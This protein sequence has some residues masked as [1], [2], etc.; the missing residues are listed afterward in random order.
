MS[1]PTPPRYVVL[2]ADVIEQA[3]VPDKPR[4]ALL[5]SFIRLLS[6][7][8]EAKYQNTP[9]LPE[10]ELIAFLKLSRRQYFDQKANMELLGW[11]RSSHP[12]PGFVQFS[13][14]RPVNEK[15]TSSAS[16][17]NRTNG[18]E[19]P[20]VVGEESL[21]RNSDPDT[22]PHQ[23]TVPA[24]A[25]NCTAS[26]ENPL[27]GGGE[28]LDQNLTSDMHSPPP[29]TPASAENRTFPATT[30]ILRHTDLL[31]NG[32][33]VA[34]RDL[35][36]RDPLHAL[37]WCAYAYANRRKV[38]GPAGIVRNRL[39]DNEVPPEWFKQHWKERLPEPFLEALGLVE[40]TCEECQATFPTRRG[41]N[42]HQD[43]HFIPSDDMD[44]QMGFEG[45]DTTEQ[46]REAEYPLASP[47]DQTIPCP[48]GPNHL[49]PV[50]AWQTVLAQLEME[51]PRASFNTWVRD[52]KA[53]RYHANTLSI[54]APNTET[55]EWLESRVASTASRLLV[56]V[57]NT[58]VA[59]EFVVDHAS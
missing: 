9:P 18:A 34:G 36:D 57:L 17:E 25:K 21:N 31:F 55:R 23:P 13:F 58:R 28:S 30:E 11:L 24:S 43:T 3:F 56:G 39:K 16:A 32:S 45:A 14:S 29:T 49:T 53:C 59:V 2:P 15:T 8:W 50:Q 26:A 1:L 12:R 38:S 27:I 48:F 44:Q 7:A 20:G 46:L 40:Y 41:L 35:A 37:A 51:M 6:L 5:A 52:T 22:D 4:R 47:G 54:A 33:L 10:E 19:N 42:E